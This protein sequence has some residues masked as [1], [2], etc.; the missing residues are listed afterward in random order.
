MSLSTF[1]HGVEVTVE[2]PPLTRFQSRYH[3][4]RTTFSLTK[5]WTRSVPKQATASDWVEARR[6]FDLGK[7]RSP[8]GYVGKHHPESATHRMV[9]VGAKE[10]T[11]VHVSFDFLTVFHRDLAGTEGLDGMEIVSIRPQVDP[12]VVPVCLCRVPSRTK[13]WCNV[14]SWG[15]G[16]RGLSLSLMRTPSVSHAAVVS[17]SRP[18]TTMSVS[19]QKSSILTVASLQSLCCYWSQRDRVGFRS[20]AR[21]GLR[22]SLRPFLMSCFFAEQVLT[23]LDLLTYWKVTATYQNEDYFLPNQL[24]EKMAITPPCV[25]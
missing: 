18:T 15:I 6:I 23:Q 16:L 2:Q 19:F 5:G 21:F 3:D 13:C 24:D 11:S 17:A 10:K 12:F 22:H 9:C 4:E 7:I 8:V 14:I 20:A 25:S 1:L